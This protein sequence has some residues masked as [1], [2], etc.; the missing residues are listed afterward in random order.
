MNNS[1]WNP[2]GAATAILTWTSTP[3]KFSCSVFFF[4]FPRTI[5]GRLVFASLFPSY[6]YSCIRYFIRRYTIN[7]LILVAAES[8]ISSI[9]DPISRCV[10]R[11]FPCADLC[12]SVCVSTFS[13][14]LSFKSYSNCYNTYFSL[15]RCFHP[16]RDTL[17][18][19]VIYNV[20]FHITAL[21]IFSSSQS[22]SLCVPSFSSLAHIPLA[23]RAHALP[24]YTLASTQRARA[25]T[26]KEIPMLAGPTFSL[27]IFLFDAKPA[28]TFRR[29]PHTLRMHT[30]IHAYSLA[31]SHT[32]AHT[33]SHAGVYRDVGAWARSHTRTKHSENTR[34][35]VRNI[36]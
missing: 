5:S 24:L 13:I 7:V 17:L 31:H 1:R 6:L 14:F 22:L 9:Q 33:H 18:F 12:V 11:V 4:S 35:C 27:S 21:C 16:L 28:L 34:V 10:S 23:R 36:P 30:N 15:L 32:H 20:D 29:S 3:A 2:N 26:F 25:Y 8:I 19:M